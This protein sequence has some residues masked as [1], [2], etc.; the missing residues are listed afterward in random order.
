MNIEEFFQQSIGKWFAHRTS[1]DLADKKSLEAKSDIVIDSV[2][3]NAPEVI[4]LCE[5]HQIQPNN[6]ACSVRINWNDTT[7]LNQKNTGSNVLVFVPDAKNKDEGQFLRSVSS[8][9]KNVPGHYKL[10][11]DESLTL[12]FETENF[13]SE[14]RMWFASSNLRMRVSVIKQGKDFSM[15]SFTSEIRM[16]VAPPAQTQATNSASK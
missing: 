12:I 14:E 7:K 9:E 10:G 11:T 5:M 8:S 6:I 13:Y 2:S 4:N 16:G 15:T 3:T 1:H